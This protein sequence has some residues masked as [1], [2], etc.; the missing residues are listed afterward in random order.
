L[1]DQDDFFYQPITA[2]TWWQYLTWPFS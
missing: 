2:T 1:L